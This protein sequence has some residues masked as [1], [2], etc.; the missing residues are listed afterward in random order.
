MSLVASFLEIVQPLSWAMST[1]VFAR[2]MTVLAGWIFAG[3]PLRLMP[4]PVDD[5]MLISYA[6]EAGLH[7][8][9]LDEL[10]Q[11]HLGHTP[12]SYDEVT[13]TGRNR[14]PFS[15]VPIERASEYPQ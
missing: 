15:Q 9:G 1:P 3:W 5:S 11:L 10:S 4:T 6:Q 14:V 12:I 13:G 2:F 7:G 8:H